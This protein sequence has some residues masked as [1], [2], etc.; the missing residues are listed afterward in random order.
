MDRLAPISRTI[1]A[2]WRGA[3]TQTS[4]PVW[5]GMIEDLKVK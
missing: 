5:I 3:L 4:Y 2:Y 1:Q